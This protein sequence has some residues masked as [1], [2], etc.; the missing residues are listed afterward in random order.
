MNRKLFRLA[1]IITGV[2]P[3]QFAAGLV[4]AGEPV[5]WEALN[6]EI[7]GATYT[8]DSQQCLECHEDFM[9]TFAYSKHGRALPKGGC[10]SCHGPMSKHMDQ[11]RR[12]PALVVSMKKL[13]A[14]QSAS[15]CL[16]CHEGGKHEG[17]KGDVR[18][19]WHV[20]SHASSG[21]ACVNCHNPVGKDDPVRARATQTKV[22]FTCHLDK[23]ARSL[24]RSRHAIREG[25]VVCSD[26]HNT[27]GSAGGRQLVK[28]TVTE[29]C[30]QCHAEK[31][32]PF[33]WEHPPVR[34]DCTLCHDPH[35]TTEERMLKVRGPFLCQQCHNEGYHPSSQYTA[36]DIPDFGGAAQQLLGKN[37]RAC[38]SVIHGSNH[39]SGSRFTR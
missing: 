14:E 28:N 1:L 6:P 15:V 37:C 4:Q 22:C 20:S 24:M 30:Y 38:H 25:E 26:C 10:E 12:E 19:N 32:G 27:H 5:N 36:A 13:T 39:P 2:I 34:E 9:R 35:G 8:D 16:S 3:L 21:V 33:L 23:R 7:E 31:R 18:M 11:P 29:T 17:P